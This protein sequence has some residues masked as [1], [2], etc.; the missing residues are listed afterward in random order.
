MPVAPSAPGRS[1]PAGTAI[2]ADSLD[3]LARLHAYN[4]WIFRALRPHLAGDVLEVGC[5]IGNMTAHLAEAADRLVGIDPVRA[6]TDRFARRFADRS[7]VDVRRCWLD[8]LAEPTVDARRF[9]RVVSCNVLEHID[10]DVAALRQMAAQLR[11][12]GKVVVFVPAGPVAFGRLDRELGH[13]RRYTRRSLRAAMR[14]AGLSWQGGEYFNRVGL[15]SWWINSVLLRRRR[16][17]MRQAALGNR[18]VGMARVIDRCT[19]LP[20]GQS[21]LGVGVKV[22]QPA[23]AAT[24][25]MVA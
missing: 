10:D 9:D 20:W 14:A 11:P 12:G 5:G 15:L 22:D 24:E 6:F 2:V 21:V 17:P 13:Y 3:T 1:Q 8:E 23:A 25:R 16:V 7:H 4:R 19:P 18:L